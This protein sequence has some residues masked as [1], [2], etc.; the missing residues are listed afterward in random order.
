MVTAADERSSVT[1]PERPDEGLHYPPDGALVHLGPKD[2]ALFRDGLWFLKDGRCA[3]P[4]APGG[5]ECT[6]LWNTTREVSRG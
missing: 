6:R 2:I 5:I 4:F 3:Y 1:T